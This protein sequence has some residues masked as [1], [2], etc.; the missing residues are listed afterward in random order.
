MFSSVCDSQIR[1]EKIA[2][3]EVGIVFKPSP[4]N[5]ADFVLSPSESVG[6]KETKLS[7]VS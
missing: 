2:P 5:Q 4:F 3:L 1:G 6:F 7:K